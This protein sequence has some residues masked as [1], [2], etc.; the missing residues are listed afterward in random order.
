MLALAGCKPSAD[1]GTVAPA[2]K[3][4]AAAH[5]IAPLAEPFDSSACPYFGAI[6]RPHPGRRPAADEP[7]PPDAYDYTL[8][9]APAESVS[10]DWAVFEATRPGSEAPVTRLRLKIVT[11]MG[12]ANRYLSTGREGRGAQVEELNRDLSFGTWEKST[13]TP[14]LASYAVLF[15]DLGRDLYYLQGDWSSLAGEVT[16]FTPE[17]AK[18]LFPNMWVLSKC[19]PETSSGG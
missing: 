9:F 17:Q 6:Y 14:W 15:T 12:I 13:D 11:S 18:P 19:G 4:K 1:R 2:S 5:L 3:F 8:S 16:F 10:E 7:S